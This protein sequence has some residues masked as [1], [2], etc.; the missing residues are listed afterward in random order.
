MWGRS[1]KSEKKE[2]IVNPL[3]S[4]GDHLEGGIL[5]TKTDIHVARQ[6]NILSVGSQARRKV[7]SAQD[8][9][10]ERVSGSFV[11]THYP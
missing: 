4:W 11:G 8:I 6:R 10:L 3:R 1:V 7:L 9:T 5:S 2:A